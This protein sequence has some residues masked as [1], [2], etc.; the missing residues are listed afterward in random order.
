MGAL[1]VLDC[2]RRFKIAMGAAR[3]LSFL[4]HELIPHIIH[5]DIKASNILLNEDFEPKVADFGLAR[6]I[7]AC[8]THTTTDVAGTFGYIPPEWEID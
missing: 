6:L 3:G 2:D 7:S 4:H 1:E 5:R 8:E